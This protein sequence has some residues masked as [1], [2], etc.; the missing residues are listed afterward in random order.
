MVPRTGMSQQ[1]CLLVHDPVVAAW[2]CHVLSQTGFSLLQLSPLLESP[3]LPTAVSP[4]AVLVDPIF[5]SDPMR[6]LLLPFL[7]LCAAR[8]IPVRTLPT[9][10]EPLARSARSLGVPALS[11]QTPLHEALAVVVD[12]IAPGRELSGTGPEVQ[13]QVREGLLEKLHH[14]Q[15][16][17]RG[18]GDPLVS[19]KIPSEQLLHAHSLA[20][21]AGVA[22]PGMI[23]QL[24]KAILQTVF[25]LFQHAP[26]PASIHRTLAQAADLLTLLLEPAHPQF[27][28]DLPPVLVVEDD[29]NTSQLICAALEIVE[30]PATPAFTAEQGLTLAESDFFGLVLLDIGLPSM[31][32]LEFCGQLRALPLHQNT[33]VVFLTG[34]TDLPHRLQS[35]LSGGNEFVCKPF[36]VHELGL[37][38]LL[39]S[40]RRALQSV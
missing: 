28:R 25:E 29:P 18:V 16:A 19:G 13:N 11:T 7:E 4:A 10:L 20:L 27:P 1:I 12:E 23:F 39:W 24:A 40:V 22:E 33:P 2:Y 35:N 32:G 8:Q 9:P 38:A 6:P 31:N 15:T 5:F 37:K 14:F 17:L 34:L 26:S 30:L 21:L 36:N 3:S